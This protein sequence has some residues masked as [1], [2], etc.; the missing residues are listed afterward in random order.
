[1]FHRK[2]V[3]WPDGGRPR[4]V[5]VIEIGDRRLYAALA[6]TPAAKA[7]TSKLSPAPLTLTLCDGG[8]EKAGTLPWPLPADNASL[9]ARAG[10]ILLCGEDEVLFCC[11]E[12]THSATRL[13]HIGN[14]AG[15]ELLRIL[16]KEKT[17]I[18]WY[19]EWSE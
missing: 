2:F 12:G 7:F 6:D 18:T 16:G 8:R 17:S 10:D 5:L 1:M 3:G 19:L 9:T 13:A 11:A 4:A 15:E 14:V